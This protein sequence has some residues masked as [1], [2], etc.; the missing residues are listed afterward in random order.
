M[1]FPLDEIAVRVLNGAA[2]ASPGMAALGV[3]LAKYLIFVVVAVPVVGAMTPQGRRLIGGW[4]VMLRALIV[5][6]LGIAGNFLLSLAFFRERPFA[7][8]EGIVPLI[9]APLFSKSY[10]SDHATVA[11]AVATCIF[12]VKPKAGAVMYAL[13][14]LVGLGRIMAGVHYPTDVL[15]G[16]LIVIPWSWIVAR[17]LPADNEEILAIDDDIEDDIQTF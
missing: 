3:F 17:A 15:A 6:G 8:L 7:A 4:I 16:A 2:N 11:F 5:I 10:P 9:D 13:A 1:T 14:L 12:L